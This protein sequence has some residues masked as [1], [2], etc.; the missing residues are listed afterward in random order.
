MASTLLQQGALH[1]NVSDA[2]RDMIVAGDLAPGSKV[3]E[4]ELCERFGISRTPLREA[5][6]VLASEGLIQLLPRRGAYVAQ[7]TQAEIDELFP[8]M[9]ALEALAGELATARLTDKDIAKFRKLHEEMFA[10]HAAGNEK[11]YLRL[12]RE[13]HQYLFAVA[14]NG[15]LTTM[16]EQILVR[17]H[18]VRFVTR[19]S[20]EQWSRAVDDHRSILDA[21]ERRD[22]AQLAALLRTHL[23]GTASDVARDTL[24]R[25]QA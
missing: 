6:K 3:R 20:A 13:I 2:L 8:I 22:G 1:H 25:Q 18:A 23:L 11:D 19:K 24:V 9:A 15:A 16:Y 14:A 5:L 4:P 12:N 7:I 17:I 10:C 21:I